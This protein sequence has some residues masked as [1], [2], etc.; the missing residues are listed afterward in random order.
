MAFVVNSHDVRLY[1]R[2]CRVISRILI[3]NITMHMRYRDIHLIISIFK[4]ETVSDIRALR[5]TLCMLDYLLPRAR[6][7]ANSLFVF[8]PVLFYIFTRVRV[9]LTCSRIH[10]YYTYIRT[11]NNTMTL[12]RYGTEKQTVSTFVH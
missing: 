2:V 11:Y 10:N 7:H 12:I 3:N 5:T 1:E 6:A 4:N 9:F 8:S